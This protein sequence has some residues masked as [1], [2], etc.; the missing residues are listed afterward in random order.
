MGLFSKLF[1]KKECAICGGEIGLLGN[2]K[3]EDG[4]MCKNCASKLSPYLTD[5]KNST[6]AEIKEHLAYRE[7]NARQVARFNP[8]TVLGHRTKLYIDQSMGKFFISSY[9]NWAAHN[10]DLIDLSQVTSVDTDVSEHKKELT[11]KDAEGKTVSY[12]PRRYEYTYEFRVK[13]GIRSEWMGSLSFELSD[14]RPQ[15][16]HNPLYRQL[17]YEGEE[18]RFALGKGPRPEPVQPAQYAMGDSSQAASFK[19]AEMPLKA[20]SAA[21]GIGKG[22]E[23]GKDISKGAQPGWQCVC[24][25][26]NTGNF[27]ASCGK[28]RPQGAPL[29]R[30]DKCGWTPEN[31]QNPPRFCP[32]CGDPFDQGD[33]V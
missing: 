9:D 11:T 5:R 29:F 31:P 14:E 10:P 27:C 21:D 28:R 23:L 17:V 24:G 15:S 2:R 32:Q 20:A 26:R 18:I 4:N 13:I 22:K 7:E 30:C 8:T 3:L 12:N 16:P 6:V 1:E 25:A 19:K 33:I